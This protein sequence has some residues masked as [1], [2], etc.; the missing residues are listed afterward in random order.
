M[1]LNVHYGC[2]SSNRV[3]QWFTVTSKGCHSSDHEDEK[4]T[5][6]PTVT[7]GSFPTT[8]FS[9]QTKSARHQSKPSLGNPHAS[10]VTALF[11]DLQ[12]CIDILIEKEF[13]ER[14]DGAKDTYRYLA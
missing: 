1:V 5:K 7:S 12:K 10:V 14:V 6:A 4:R 13:L 9:I 3:C 2:S 11:R 8:F